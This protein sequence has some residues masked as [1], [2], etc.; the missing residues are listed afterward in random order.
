[1]SSGGSAVHGKAATASSS[2]RAGTARFECKLDQYPAVIL[3]IERPQWTAR[4]GDSRPVARRGAKIRGRE[5]RDGNNSQSRRSR[6]RVYY[7]SVV[8]RV[9]FSG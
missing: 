4:M 1:M 3:A 6:P 7:P 8:S 5:K 9:H 2:R